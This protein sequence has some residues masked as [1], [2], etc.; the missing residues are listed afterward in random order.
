MERAWTRV[1]RRAI[2]T[3]DGLLALT[4][5]SAYFPVTRM[6]RS[7]GEIDSNAIQGRCRR[8]EKAFSRTCSEKALGRLAKSFV[9]RSL[10][11]GLA[12][13]RNVP[14]VCRLENLGIFSRPPDLK[15]IDECDGVP[16]AMAA[17]NTCSLVAIG[18]E[19]GVVR[20]YD[21]SPSSAQTSIETD[22][23]HTQVHS[24]A[25]FDMQWSSD[26]KYIITAGGDQEA[27]VTD[28]QTQDAVTRFKNGHSSSIKVAIFDPT[29]PA[30]CATGGRD[31]TI[32][33]WD[34]RC[35]GSRGSVL[36]WYESQ[37]PIRYC[38]HP[39]T[40]I[41]QNVH[42]R[43]IVPKVASKSLPPVSITAMLYKHDGQLVTAC[44]AN[45]QLKT[46]DLRYARGLN[47][48]WREFPLLEDLSI[49][50]P[51]RLLAE[52]KL[53]QGVSGLAESSSRRRRDF[54]VTSL[55]LSHDGQRIYS[56]NRDNKVYAYPSS[57]PDAAPVAVFDV[58]ELQVKSFYCKSSI[59]KDG[60]LVVG[61]HNGSPVIIDT[62]RTTAAST[63]DYHGGGGG[64]DGT[65]DVS[66]DEDKENIPH[67][68]R[69]SRRVKSGAMSKTHTTER[70]RVGR[71]FT[72]GHE[73]EATAI[74]WSHD[75]SVLLTMSDDRT[76]RT[77]RRDERR[78]G[79]QVLL[80]EKGMLG[81]DDWAFL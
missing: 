72:G 34:S 44:A 2:H 4:S 5:A 51:S 35:H 77:W 50:R 12:Y 52:E 49:P 27:I 75:S 3:N 21:H 59:S 36:S 31:G 13:A 20:I 67:A 60:F 62:E 17:A 56:T 37:D 53:H 76:V 63:P 22:L 7:F 78:T 24:N 38:G 42:G 61:N 32:A 80:D 19:S 57:H 66:S 55:A 69:D 9:R 6:K 14:D 47:S 41:L 64:G 26:D 8:P 23:I 70:R 15:T 48:S 33:I 28:L 73:L 45:S 40:A 1:K 43:P 39:P 79:R 74:A 71:M 18:H 29:K 81:A 58:P 46:W 10:H 68:A 25:I 11:G 16:F 65:T 54:G 30:L